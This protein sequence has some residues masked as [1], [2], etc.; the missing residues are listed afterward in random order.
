MIKDRLFNSPQIISEL[1]FN[2]FS[3]SVPVLSKHITFTLPLKLIRWGDIEN[4]LNFL[5]LS[6]K[7]KKSFLRKS[8]NLDKETNMPMDMHAG[9]EGG[10]T[11]VIISRDF[12]II[13]LVFSP[14]LY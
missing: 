13:V 2:E 7:Y 12:K 10:T 8:S 5:S 9:R 1:V 6:R 11:M 14:F 4:I 3:V